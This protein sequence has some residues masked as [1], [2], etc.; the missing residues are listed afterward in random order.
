MLVQSNEIKCYCAIPPTR[1]QEPKRWS[2]WKSKSLLTISL[3]T[4]APNFLA[5]KYTSCNQHSDHE[6]NFISSSQENNNLITKY[7][8]HS[9]KQVWKLCKVD[10]LLGYDNRTHKIRSLQNDSVYRF[11]TVL[12]NC[13]VLKGHLSYTSK[14]CGYLMSGAEKEFMFANHL[15]SSIF[16]FT[17]FCFKTGE[18]LVYKLTHTK[19]YTNICQAII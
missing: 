2:T 13:R 16:F 17:L 7:Q 5:R 9:N 4:S 14:F 8:R 15:L 11:P 10:G 1:F 19:S 12:T 18:I 3:H 6:P